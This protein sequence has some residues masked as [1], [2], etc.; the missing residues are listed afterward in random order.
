MTI[1]I[2]NDVESPLASEAEHVLPLCAFPE[3]AVAATKSYLTSLSMLARLV[4][5]WTQ[6]NT[7]QV[8]LERLPKALAA[9][10]QLDWSAADRSVMDAT[11]MFVIGRG[12]GLGIAQEAALKFKET[13]RIHAEAY[14]AAEVLHGPAAV[15]RQD[16]P[17]LAFLQDDAT[18]DSLEETCSKLAGMGSRVFVAG[19]QVPG[20]EQL[21]TVDFD[22]RLQPVLQAQSFYALV[23]RCAVSLGQNP[24]EPPHLMKVTETT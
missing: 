6:D 19:A 2:V 23:N 9:A 8:S 16:F 12:A 24:D 21:P 13:C 5:A 7:L 14:S 22:A 4:A 10:W 18:A 3:R 1:A 15:V 11:S 17:V 20:C